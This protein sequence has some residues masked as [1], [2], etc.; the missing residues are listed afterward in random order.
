MEPHLMIYRIHLTP[1]KLES[2]GA[3]SSYKRCPG[4]T[5]FKPHQS[6]KLNYQLASYED[7]RPLSLPQGQHNRPLRTLPQMILS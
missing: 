7:A 3:P 5:L 1:C 2:G 4:R 6:L